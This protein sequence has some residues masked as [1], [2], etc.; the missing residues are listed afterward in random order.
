METGPAHRYVQDFRNLAVWQRAVDLAGLIFQ[1]TAKFPKGRDGNLSHQ[2][3]KAGVSIGLNIAEGCGRK[4]GAEFLRYLQIAMGSASE[5]E[6]G[7]VLSQK[8]R[9]LDK[10]TSDQL[11]ERVSEVKRML[12]GLMK[13]L[14]GR[15]GKPPP[16][17]SPLPGS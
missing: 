16:P 2:M 8:L 5:V 7:L 10:D 17:D 4:G 3:R 9:L 14:G 11:I 1:A 6:G 13:S 12:T 15:W